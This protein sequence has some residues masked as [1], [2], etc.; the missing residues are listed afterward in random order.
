MNRL[1]QFFDTYGYDVR[2][3]VRDLGELE[4]AFRELNWD[5]PE[6]ARL[7]LAVPK[8]PIHP[9]I[10]A[11]AAKEARPHSPPARAALAPAR[12]RHARQDMAG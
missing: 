5:M 4:A 9:Q 6:L 10:R 12:W 8:C 2:V 7:P 1:I 3:T 11:L